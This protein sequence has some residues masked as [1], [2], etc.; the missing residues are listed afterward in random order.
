LADRAGKRCFD[1]GTLAL[2]FFP[3]FAED[4]TRRAERQLECNCVLDISADKN[5]RIHSVKLDLV[6][7]RRPHHSAN[8]LFVRA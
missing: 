1:R 4:L 5:G 6:I 3:G 8:H 7:A 2:G